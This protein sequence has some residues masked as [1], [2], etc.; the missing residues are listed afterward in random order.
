MCLVLVLLFSWWRAR[1][2]RLASAVVSIEVC[3]SRS[4]L[5]GLPCLFGRGQFWKRWLT[6]TLKQPVEIP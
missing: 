4:L 6:S 2:V 5:R 1:V 3:G